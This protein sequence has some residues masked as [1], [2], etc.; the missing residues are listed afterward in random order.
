MLTV[1]FIGFSIEGGKWNTQNNK[2]I[3]IPLFILI[4]TKY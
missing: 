1:E 2:I 3:L 4:L